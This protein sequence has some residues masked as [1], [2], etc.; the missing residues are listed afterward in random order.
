MALLELIKTFLRWFISTES[1]DPPEQDPAPPAP[2]GVQ[3]SSSN[4]YGDPVIEVT[5]H[6][7]VGL[8]R[9]NGHIPELMMSTYLSRAFE[10]ANHSY[11][12]RWNF[13]PKT[14]P[15]ETRTNMTG[16]GSPLAYWRH[17][18]KQGLPNEEVAKDV[19]LLLVD[20]DSGG[21]SFVGGN[22]AIAPGRHIESERRWHAT[23]EDAQSRNIHATLHE[24]G[25]SL[26][27]RHDHDKTE[28]GMQHP[29]M[30]WNDHERQVW[31]RTPTV[32][33]NGY[34]NL[35]GEDIPER[36]YQRFTVRHQT[37]HDCAIAN[38]DI[39]PKEQ[40]NWNQQT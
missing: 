21:I 29:G 30:A 36:E 20:A 13:T 8:R 12:I 4:E 17:Q 32:A 1:D 6:S 16:S 9:R 15:R 10:E 31:H 25:H 35:C 22:V 39:K 23:G 14:P 2:R 33:G 3:A 26:G 7:S 18:V 37:F 34:P 5:L 24:T 19:N 27:A 38:F 40:S 11:E 28:P